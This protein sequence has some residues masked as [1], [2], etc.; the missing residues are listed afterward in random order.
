MAYKNARFFLSGYV[1]CVTQIGIF[2]YCM[3][4]KSSTVVQFASKQSIFCNLPF[5]VYC[6]SKIPTTCG[7]EKQFLWSLGSFIQQ[8]D[9]FINAFVFGSQSR[10]TF[11]ERH[12]KNQS[13]HYY[14]HYLSVRGAK[15]GGRPQFSGHVKTSAFSTNAQST[16]RQLFLTESRDMHA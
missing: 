7:L 10:D 6:T 4:M 12:V 9:I 16:L 14:L 11:L 5:S 8:S 13:I 15:E 1:W 2:I 3:K